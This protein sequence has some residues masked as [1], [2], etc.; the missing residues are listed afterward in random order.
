MT[1]ETESAI[2]TSQQRKAQDYMVSPVNSAE[3]LKQTNK[4]T[5]SIIF[6]LFQK[7]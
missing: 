5:T 3:H 6:K 2:K 1:K 4:Q 7:L